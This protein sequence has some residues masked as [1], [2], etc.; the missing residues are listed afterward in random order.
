MLFFSFVVHF[1][2][3]K[4]IKAIQKFSR[5]FARQGKSLCR[6]PF[7]IVFILLFCN[8]VRKITSAFLFFFLSSLSIEI[9]FFTIICFRCTFFLLS[10][11]GKEIQLTNFH[12]LHSIH[13]TLV[14]F[15]IFILHCKLM[16][17]KLIFNT[18]PRQIQTSYVFFSLTTLSIPPDDQHLFKGASP[19]LLHFISFYFR[20]LRNERAQKIQIYYNLKSYCFYRGCRLQYIQFAV[21]VTFIEFTIASAPSLKGLPKDAQILSQNIESAFV[22]FSDNCIN[23]TL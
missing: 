18:S 3:I 22:L 15:N 9:A 19:S 21:I 10:R 11:T 4:F 5:Y 7:K 6:C 12:A 1:D 2:L 14:D 8:L 17:L 23:Q 13:R 16:A 20:D